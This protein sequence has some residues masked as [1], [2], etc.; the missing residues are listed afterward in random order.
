MA[1]NVE[2]HLSGQRISLSCPYYSSEP[3]NGFAHSLLESLTLLLQEGFEHPIHPKGGAG[4]TLFMKI[5]QCFDSHIL[6]AFPLIENPD[7]LRVQHIYGIKLED[8]LYLRKD[9][10]L[11]EFARTFGTQEIKRL[12]PDV[13]SKPDPDDS[14][15]L[16]TSFDDLDAR[17]QK[18]SELG[19]LF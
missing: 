7:G 14:L 18:R 16:A 15:Q 8:N 9:E 19:M 12:I 2:I 10:I 13:V 4:V 6:M 1:V 5:P 3:H 17:D 11:Q